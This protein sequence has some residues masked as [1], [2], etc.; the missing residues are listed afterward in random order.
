MVFGFIILLVE[1]VP[2]MTIGRKQENSQGFGTDIVEGELQMYQVEGSNGY[3]FQVILQA[4]GSDY[5]TIDLR[6]YKPI[7]RGI[8]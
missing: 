2:A 8:K 1:N 5:L 4:E 6:E 3:H 7:D